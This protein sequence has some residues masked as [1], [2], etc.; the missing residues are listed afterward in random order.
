[1]RIIIAVCVW[2]VAASAIAAE[3]SWQ[4]SILKPATLKKVSAASNQY[5]RCMGEQLSSYLDS[6]QDP[7][8]ITDAILKQCES[9]LQPMRDAF[10]AEKVPPE[11]ADRYLHK[12]RTHAARNLIREV[13]AMQAVRGIGVK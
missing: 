7:R 12:T 10:I 6:G 1:M 4:E 11:M 5:Q 8:G 13:M 2:A 3:Q 9:Q